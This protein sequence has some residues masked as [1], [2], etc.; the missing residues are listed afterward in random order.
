MGKGANRA[1]YGGGAVGAAGRSARRSGAEMYFNGRADMRQAY[2]AAIEYLADLE[3]AAV[4]I[5]MELDYYDYPVAALFREMT[6]Y[7]PR[8]GHIDV[9]NVSEFCNI[10]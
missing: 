7:A 4:G 1:S 10:S 9:T 5:C 6:G 2:I 8:L 3:P